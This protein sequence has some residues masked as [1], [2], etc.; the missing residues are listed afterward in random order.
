MIYYRLLIK[1]PEHTWG[2]P[3]VYDNSNW[4]NVQF[5]D[6][7]SGMNYVNC[8]LAWLEQRSYL[9]YAIEVEREFVYQMPSLYRFTQLIVVM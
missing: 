2:L 3:G 5:N 8:T 1:I 4:T 9:G 6:A 7:K